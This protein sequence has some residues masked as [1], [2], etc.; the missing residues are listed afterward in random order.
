MAQEPLHINAWEALKANVG[1]VRNQ[2]DMIAGLGEPLQDAAVLVG[3]VLLGGNK[4]LL[5]G[6]GGS[7]CDAAHF[8]AEIAGRYRLDRPGFPAVDLTAEHAVVM[9][10]ANDFPPEQVFARRV[11]AMGV[12]GDVLVVF[13]T[14]GQSTNVRLALDAA[15]AKQIKTIA[16]LGGDGGDCCGRADVE[17]LVRSHCTARVQE[18]HLLLYHTMCEVLDPVLA[19]AAPLR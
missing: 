11:Q 17:L 19:V 3:E 12:P 8:A 16:M 2:L 15:P 7:A 4:L 6:N 13:S 1:E 9:A 10:L 14:S 5:C 18:A